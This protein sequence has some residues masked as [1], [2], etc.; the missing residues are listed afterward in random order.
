MNNQKLF[1]IRQPSGGE[2]I[3][4]N[5]NQFKDEDEKNRKSTV[6]ARRKLSGG[7]KMNFSSSLVSL[8]WLFCSHCEYVSFYVL[9]MYIN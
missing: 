5:L 9:Q 1:Q 2:K 8:E 6:T 7:G 3:S 4:E